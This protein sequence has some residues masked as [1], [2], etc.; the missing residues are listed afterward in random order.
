MS[1]GR[2]DSERLHAAADRLAKRAVLFDMSELARESGTVINAV[3][4]GAMAGSGALPVSRAACEDAIRAHGK[5]AEASLRGFAAGYAHASGAA[6]QGV[7]EA[8]KVWRGRPVERVRREF[9]PETHRIVEEGV[10]RLVDYQD[11][12]Y[13]DLYLDRLALVVAAERD[14]GG[15]P[16]GYGIA[17]ETARYLALWMSYEDIIRVADLKSRRSRFERVRAEVLAQPHEP[18]HIVEFLKPGVEEFAA[19]LPRRLARRVLDWAARKGK[20]FNVGMHVKTTSVSG[21]LL[22]RA[23][24]WLRPLRRRTSRFHD[25]QELIERW[26]AAIWSACGPDLALATEVARLGHLIKGY[27]E[28]HKRGRGNF[29]RIMDTLVDATAGDVAAMSV[30]ERATAIREAH[31][32]AFAD[33]EG[34]KLEHSLEAVGIAPLPPQAKPI[35]FMKRPASSQ[36]A[37]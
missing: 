32:A 7:R 20:S 6:S 9:P 33:P 36:R 27:G 37:G 31:A 16:S 22:V 17:N 11:A 21:Y 26:L 24:A 1:D 4:F 3:L 29:V 8:G 15:G 34:R 10:A 25:E 14:A 12:A 28:T 2:F 13:A 19:I 18:V 30:A 5:G 35:K 23:L